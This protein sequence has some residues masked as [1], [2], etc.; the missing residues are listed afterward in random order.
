VPGKPNGATV[1]TH[2]GAN[3]FT[4]TAYLP[5]SWPYRVSI[6]ESNGNPCQLTGKGKRVLLRHN[7]AGP[8]CFSGDYICK[9][10]LL[11]KIKEGD[12]IVV[13]DTGSYTV[14]MYSRYNSRCCPPMYGFTMRE[15]NK[16]F[17]EGISFVDFVVL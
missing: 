5:E 8:L 1:L 4:R 7:I 2:V 6:A 17:V 11:P 10:R 14:S 15:E 16:I 13:H 3:L 9:D 12:I